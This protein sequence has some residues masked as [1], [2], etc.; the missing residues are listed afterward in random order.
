MEQKSMTALVSAFARWHHAGHNGV[1]VFDDSIAGKLLTDD[2]KRQIADS[3]GKGIGFFNPAF[4]GTE[5]EALRWIVNNQL[6]PSP[7]GRSAWAEKALQAAVRAGAEQYVIVAAGYDT[8]AYR[9]PEWA[10][11]LRVFELDSPFMSLDKQ[12]R[13][14]AAFGGA[15]RNVTFAPIDLAAESLSA[16][17]RS[18]GAFGKGAPTFFSLLGISYYLAKERF[19]ALIRDIAGASSSSSTIALD[20]PDELTYTERA[21]ER[22]RKQAMMARG[23]GGSYARGLCPR[24]DG[25]AAV[26]RRLYRSRAPIAGRNNRTVFLRI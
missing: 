20:Y 19:T 14:Q 2:E 15:P 23:A 26:R 7:L 25:A 21:G 6:A 10:G 8:F 9:Q 13:V 22:A 17:L 24:G 1:K 5:E 11:K 12:K 3:M 16:A 4:R 18:C